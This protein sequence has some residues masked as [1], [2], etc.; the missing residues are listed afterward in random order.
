MV[1]TLSDLDVADVSGMIAAAVAVIQFFIP[2]ALPVVLLGVLKE[3]QDS[4]TTTLRSHGHIVLVTRLKTILAFLTAIAAVVTPLGL[5]QTLVEDDE[6]TENVSFHYIQDPSDFGYGTPPRVDLPWSRICGIRGS[7]ECPNSF[8]NVT[9]FS[10]ESGDYFEIH[11]YDTRVP[12]YVI[13]VFQSGLKNMESSVSSIFVIQVRS[14]SWES[15]DNKPGATAPDN[16]QPYPVDSFRM[17]SSKILADDYLAVEG[18]VVDMKNGGIGFRNH[19][20]PPWTPYGSTWSE[21]LLFIEPEF[22][23]GCDEPLH[24]NPFNLSTAKFDSAS[25]LCSGVD[26]DDVAG[27]NNFAAVCGLVFGTP[28]RTD[29]NVKV[30]PD[31][32]LQSKRV[33]F[34]FNGTDDLSGI[35]I[36]EINNKVYQDEESKPL[37]GVE[38]S[39]LTLDD[40]KPLWGLISS[41]DQGN[42]S[43]YTLRQESLPSWKRSLH[44]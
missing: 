12:Q 28:K 18:L 13:D 7:F 44:V 36:T 9:T 43:L 11:H 22:S 17:I 30:S 37:W 33:T 38:R 29:R 21:D 19:S 40:A 2:L 4:S 39:N 35:K 20:A 8:S 26:F 27:I 3:E 14:H 31:P 41:P 25:Y 23:V 16:G 24:G 34:R 32:R 42:V 5:Y 1:V 6:L 15:V 10:N